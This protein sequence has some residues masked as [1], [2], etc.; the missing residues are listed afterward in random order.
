[1]TNEVRLNKNV[2]RYIVENFEVS[3]EHTE[4]IYRM[5]EGPKYSFLLKQT[6]LVK[7]ISKLEEALKGG[8]GKFCNR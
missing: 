5:F 6:E 1:M 4:N 7:R 3:K 8:D 2:V